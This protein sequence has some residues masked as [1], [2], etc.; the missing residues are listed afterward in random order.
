MLSQLRLLVLDLDYLF[1]D[2]AEL[3]VR[4]LRESLLSFADAIPPDVHLPGAA[5]IEEAFRYSGFRWP[6]ALQ[7][8]LDERH[9]TELQSAYRIYEER[10]VA[11]GAGRIFQHLPAFLSF[12]RKNNLVAAIGGE[13]SRDYLLA[14][15]DHHNLD[16]FF[17]L[18]YCVEEFGMGGTDEMIDEIMC[19]AEV[20]PSETV[21]L[22][23]RP[24]FFRA[25]RNRDILTIGCGWGLRRHE[26]LGE[27]DFQA[28]TV[29]QAC[30]AL[31]K[32]DALARQYLG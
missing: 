10:L 20:N 11:A 1:Y 26:A 28:V 27:A 21:V 19:R 31:E 3:K 7:I 6:Q 16:H 29:V 2:C 15:S 12:C 24:D 14:V 4:A 23:T 18:A 25:A 30:E 8:G 22:G 32:A 9:L 13:A 17:E 5:D